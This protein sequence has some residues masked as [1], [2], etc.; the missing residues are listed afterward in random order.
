M[1]TNSLLTQNN[2]TLVYNYQKVIIYS[3]YLFKYI[4]KNNCVKK[5]K[6]CH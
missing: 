2:K 1:Y 6:K 5:Q 4:N 3:A